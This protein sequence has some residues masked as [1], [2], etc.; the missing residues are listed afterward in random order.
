VKKAFPTI[1]LFFLALVFPSTTFL[2]ASS[3]PK[4]VIE[5]KEFDF[6]DVPEGKVVEHTFKVL[7]K[8][9]QPLLIH[10]VRPG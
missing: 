3:G 6:K 5:E 4:I 10:T 9:D 8:G 2:Q 1:V 7:N